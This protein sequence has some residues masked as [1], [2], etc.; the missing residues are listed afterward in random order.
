MLGYA[1][2]LLTQW[3]DPNYSCGQKV[4]RGEQHSG[5][6]PRHIS[7]AYGLEL[8]TRNTSDSGTKSR[9]MLIVNANGFDR[10]HNTFQQIHPRMI[11]PHR[12][13]R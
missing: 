1:I 5:E 8:L 12:Y 6:R 4:T 11:R 2:K 9:I 10:L 13:S 3:A 7:L